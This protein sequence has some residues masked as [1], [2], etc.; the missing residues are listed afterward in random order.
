MSEYEEGSLVRS[1]APIGSRASAWGR[2]SMLF[3]PRVGCSN[4]CQGVQ[5]VQTK[6][7]LR[8]ASKLL[9]R[10]RTV[11]GLRSAP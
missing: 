4:T 10:T 9:R 8:F 3:G 11:F 7:I 1:A 6:A 2:L 5:G